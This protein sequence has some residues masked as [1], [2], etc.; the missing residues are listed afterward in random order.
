M[1]NRLLERSVSKDEHL[2][3]AQPADS[4]P[5]ALTDNTPA[6]ASVQQHTTAPA[7]PR[8]SLTPAVR[9]IP[10][11][12]VRARPEGYGERQAEW[13]CAQALSLAGH[14]PLVDPSHKLSAAEARPFKQHAP[15]ALTTSGAGPHTADTHS[16]PHPHSPHAEES[17]RGQPFS[18]SGSP[19][20]VS[21]LEH[22]LC[23]PRLQLQQLLQH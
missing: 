8:V 20:S 13:V 15:T 21:S 1:S 14:P 17:S 11:V 4:S 19:S 16:H 18:G 3:V 22:P 5:P 23:L 10:V 9:V 7:Q 6:T 12:R 2:P